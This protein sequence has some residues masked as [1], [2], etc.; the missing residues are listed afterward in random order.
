MM[1]LY[2]NISYNIQTGISLSL[3][4][5]IQHPPLVLCSLNLS[6]LNATSLAL[7]RGSSGARR[8][9]RDDLQIIIEI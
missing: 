5:A 6:S 8:L 2:K 7:I 1:Q 9:L 3:G 4:R